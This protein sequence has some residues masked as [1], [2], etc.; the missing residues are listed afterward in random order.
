[1]NSSK[2]ISKSSEK[3]QL[4][5]RQRIPEMSRV[6]KRNW[7]VKLNSSINLRVRLH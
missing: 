7:A 4:M 5:I 6:W 3:L 2:V 1:M